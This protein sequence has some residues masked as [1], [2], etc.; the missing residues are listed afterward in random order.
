MAVRF[1]KSSIQTIVSLLVMVGVSPAV[2]GSDSLEA[3]TASPGGSPDPSVVFAFQ[4]DVIL[5]QQE[6]DAAFSAIPEAQRLAFIRDGGKVDQLVKAL[7]KRKV[8]AA[9]SVRADFE[10]DPLVAARVR[11]AAQKELAEAWLEHVVSTAPEANYEELARE[12]Y[13]VNPE[14]YRLPET[15]D[16][17][18]ILIGTNDRSEE[19]A[20]RLA[21]SLHGW[22]EKDPARFDELVA[23]YSDDPETSVSQGRYPEIGRGQTVPAFERAAFA[24]P[25]PGAISQPVKTQHGYHIIRLNGRSGGEIPPFEEVRDQAIEQ[26]RYEYLEGYRQRYLQSLLQEPIVIPDGAVEIMAK[27]HFGE[28]LEGVPD[29]VP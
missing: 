9:D 27:R 4:G 3:Q 23:K 18:H 22:L 6:L 8:V 24:L 12:D 28:D 17:S 16:V 14:R 25:E 21:T 13:L 2:S 26:V 29:P 15:L 5:T 11:L 20:K 19:E 7:L 1:L 10:S